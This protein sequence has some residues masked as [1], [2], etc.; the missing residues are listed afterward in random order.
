ML[1]IFPTEEK[2]GEKN[3]E[4]ALVPN[5]IYKGAIGYNSADWSISANII[6]NALYVGS[7]SSTK[8]YFLTNRQFA[9]YS[10]QKIWALNTFFLSGKL[11]LQLY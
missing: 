7:K 8:E 2:A 6:G 11:H 10:S 5:A 4:F 1:L 9:F 3:N